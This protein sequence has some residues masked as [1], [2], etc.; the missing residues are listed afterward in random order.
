MSGTM[1]ALRHFDHAPVKKVGDLA[2]KVAN[3]NPRAGRWG[4]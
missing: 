2:V 1:V 3:L 4:R